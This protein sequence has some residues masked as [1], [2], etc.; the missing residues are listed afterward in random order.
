ML[1]EFRFLL[2]YLRPYRLGYLLGGGAIALGV[3][4]KVWIPRLLG[5]SIDALG[6][7]ASEADARA[8]IAHKALLI[9][10][11]AVSVGIVRT[12][13]RVVILGNCRRVVRDVRS[14]LFARL[15]RLD[16]PF[17]VRTPTGHLMSRA[18]NDMSSVQG[19]AGPV[20]M[21][22]AETTALYSA[23]LVF[24]FHTSPRLTWLGLLPFPFFL[25]ATRR[26]AGRIQRGSRAAQQKLSEVSAKVDESLSG[27]EVVKTLALEDTDLERFRAHCDEYRELNLEVS[28]ARATLFP[29][30]LTLASLATVV[31]LLF[32]GPAVARRD[33]SLGRLVSMILYLQMMAGP[34]ATLG[35]VISSLQ[36]GAAALARVRE[37]FEIPPALFDGPSSVEALPAGALEV[38]DL[39]V[40]FP[41][42]EELPRLSGADDED[43][44]VPSGGRTVLRDVS[45]EV[46][47]G[48]TLGIVGPVGAGKTS[49]VRALVRQLPIEPGRVFLDGTDVTAL[50]LAAVRRAIAYVPQDTW[51]FGQTLAQN[52]ALGRP[53]ASRDEIEEA[54]AVA[55][56]TADLPQIAGGWEAVLG[57]RGVTLSGGQRQRTAIARAL[58]VGARLL[59]LDDALSAVDARTAES[60]LSRL[61]AESRGRTTLLVSHRIA[62][63]RHADLILVLCDGRVVERGTHEELVRSGGLYAELFRRQSD[64]DGSGEVLDVFEQAA[65]E[66]GPP[67]DERPGEE[68]GT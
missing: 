64:E 45:F 8:A 34:T 57:P 51:L 25:L 54:A 22:L 10:L 35:F 27:Q 36:R 63:V 67:A 11:L 47:A 19:L 52:V 28:R 21:Y 55:Q 12:T 46:P 5:D 16:P 40:R 56:L 3:S 30:M 1:R 44:G 17:Y 61:R 23:C 31:V 53:R 20:F 43:A 29:T 65:P 49:L 4:L 68:V 24:M 7:G 42:T 14:R 39:T 33:L 60:I 48:T 2:P 32:G 26:L 62:T 38:R 13:S 18:V 6:P 66:V 15:L 50:P 59:V 41:P 58:L 9:V 37:V